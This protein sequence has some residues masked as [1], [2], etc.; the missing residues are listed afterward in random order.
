MLEENP[1]GKKCTG[2][3]GLVEEGSEIMKEDFED[4][5]LEPH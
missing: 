2:M 3:E 5:L 1:K 4:A